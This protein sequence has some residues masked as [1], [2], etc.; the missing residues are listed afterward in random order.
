MKNNDNTYEPRLNRIDFP[1]M[2]F[3]LHVVS[4][5]KCISNIDISFEKRLPC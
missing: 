2:Q 3:I 1:I 5:L 4:S